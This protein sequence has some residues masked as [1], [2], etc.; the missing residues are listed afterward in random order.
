MKKAFFT[1]VCLSMAILA[2]TT[3]TFQ[4]TDMLMHYGAPWMFNLY[5]ADPFI[6]GD[7]NHSQ[8]QAFVDLCYAR[9]I[10]T[11]VLQ[12]GGSPVYTQNR[13]TQSSLTGSSGFAPLSGHAYP[14]TTYHYVFGDRYTNEKFRIY[15][16]NHINTENPNAPWNTLGV[17]GDNRIYSG[18]TA[19]IEHNTSTIPGYYLPEYKLKLI[20]CCFYSFSPYPPAAGTGENISG[21]GWGTIDPS[22]GDQDWINAL[23]NDTGQVDFTFESPSAVVQMAFG[24]YNGETIISPASFKREVISSYDVPIPSLLDASEIGINLTVSSGNYYDPSIPA[25]LHSSMAAKFH[26]PPIGNYPVEIIKVYPGATWEIGSTFN[27]CTAT[28]VFDFGDVPGISNPQNLRL[29]R[30]TNGFGSN[31]YDTNA[32]LIS[33]D[34]VVFETSGYCI[35]GQY[36][37]GSTGG[38]SFGPPAPQNVVITYS[39]SEVRAQIWWDPVPGALYYNVYA[40][41]DPNTPKEDWELLEHMPASFTAFET[42]AYPQKR[43][44]YVTAEK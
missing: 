44:F 30:R 38:N 37:L 29:L 24:E 12:V 21:Y 35:M 18:A 20:N 4:N 27:E 39:P 25:S 34:P 23:T 26:M 31:W 16:F 10:Y 33:T 32:T 11:Y 2:A 3:I 41:V 6:R 8:I 1:L 9:Q 43:F 36:C 7:Y 22:V 42:S 17:A 28:A 15:S 13:L 14:D 40:S 19:Y 5:N